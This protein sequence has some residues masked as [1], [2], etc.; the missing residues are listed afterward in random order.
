MDS[1]SLG[2]SFLLW[3]YQFF[4]VIFSF[5]DVLLLIEIKQQLQ[6]EIVVSFSHHFF[7]RMIVRPL[8]LFLKGIGN[9]PISVQD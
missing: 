1:I 8:S 3:A 6:N 9:V 5:H 7:F 2:C 4:L